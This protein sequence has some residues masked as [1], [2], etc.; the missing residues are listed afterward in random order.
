LFRLFKE[1]T[2]TK[3]S[4]S[5]NICWKH[6]NKFTEH[7]KVTDFLIT[8]GECH[9]IFFNK[10]TNVSFRILTITD[11]N[12][13]NM[14]SVKIHN[15]NYVIKMKETLIS[16]FLGRFCSSCGASLVGGG[17]GGKKGTLL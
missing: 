14:D 17:G 8:S 13:L 1:Y 3:G 16:Y 10:T 9:N 2:E 7:G 12:H 11:R 6:V 5:E 4:I 15:R